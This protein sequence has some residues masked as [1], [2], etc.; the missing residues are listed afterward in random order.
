MFNAWQAMDNK[1]FIIEVNK[2][3]LINIKEKHNIKTQYVLL[4]VGRHIKA[5]GL[6]YL[7]DAF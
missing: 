3:V 5:K 2:D 7:I 1:K 4:F 6:D